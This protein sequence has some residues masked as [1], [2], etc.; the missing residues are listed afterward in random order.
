MIAR[1]VSI[2]ETTVD[3]APA[4]PRSTPVG[5]TP[6]RLAPWLEVFSNNLA[7]IALY[8]KMGF[9]QAGRKRQAVRVGEQF[10]DILGMAYLLER[11]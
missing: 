2:R 8:R 6:P 7:A 9:V 11:D 3:D 1:L 10:V 4:L 5:A